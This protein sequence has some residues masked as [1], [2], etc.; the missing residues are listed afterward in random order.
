[1]RARI[2]TRCLLIFAMLF[3]AQLRL[4]AQANLPIY[5]ENLVNGF[6]NWSWISNNFANT[7]PVHSG[8]FSISATPTNDWEALS[9]EQPIYNSYQGGFNNT[10]YSAF[11]F[12]ANGGST[13]G[14]LLQVTAQYGVAGA[15][16]PTVSLAALPANSWQQFTIPLSSLLPAGTSNLNRL[17]I[18]LTPNGTTN[19]F[20]VDDVSLTAQPA[21]AIQHLA[22]D[23]SQTLR[24]ADARWFG[25]N[26]AV[27]DG[28]LDTSATS[29]ALSQAGVLSLR[30]PGGSLSYQYHWATGQS[31]VWSGGLPV[32][33]N[34]W[35]TAFPNFMHVATNRGAQAFIT[36]NY[37]SG[38]SNEAAAWVR[39]ANVT[40]H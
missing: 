10:L 6:Q 24:A 35:S 18:Q 5:T 15:S 23:A 37:G 1:M 40:N 16:G 8:T 33:T 4:M 25:V 19:T 27:W 31:I 11:V 12:W 20:Y 38:T 22:V 3:G 13:G 36:V 2:W 17:N 21:T 28:N 26:T 29:N 30:F 9:F 34:F 14:Q 7:S 32:M 39:N